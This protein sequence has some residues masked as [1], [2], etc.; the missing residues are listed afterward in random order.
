MGVAGT[1]CEGG[2]GGGP[3]YR[4]H[5][6]SLSQASNTLSELSC[7]TTMSEVGS[8][9]EE[10]AGAGAAQVATVGIAIDTRL[11][12]CTRHSLQFRPNTVTAQ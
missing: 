6:T 9:G 2:A 5:R 12:H 10:E 1:G 8:E 4:G 7:A 11:Q 3:E